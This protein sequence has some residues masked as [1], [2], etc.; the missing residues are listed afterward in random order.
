MTAGLAAEP[1]HDSATYH[2]AQRIPIGGSD[3]SYDYLRLDPATQHLY[4]AHGTRVDVLDASTGAHIGEIGRLAG[5]HGIEF[6]GEGPS[7][8]ATSGVDR[9]VVM[10]DRRSLKIQRFIK[11]TGVK[12]DALAFDPASR[13]LF[14][15]NG[16]TTG[17]LT[18]IDPASGAIIATV[19]LQGGKLE[20]IAF[21]GRG[22]GYVNDEKQSVVHVFDSRTL[23]PIARWPLGPGEEPT[24]LAMDRAGGRIFAACGNRLLV[25]VD[26]ATGRVVATAPIGADPD[27]A[28]YDAGRGRVF[29]SNRDGTLS[30]VRE[31]APGRFVPEQTVKTAP[32]ART[33][34]LD[35]SSGRLFLPY[36]EFGPAPPPTPAVPEPAAP[37]I[38]G[39][40]G[41]LVVAP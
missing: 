33:I 38:P 36:A 19:E 14:V 31:V 26:I 35:E 11:Y 21:D 9:A 7:G 20:Q 18:V 28:A 24:G 40:F 39:S 23:E 30:V 34:A 22:R 27:G 17:D 4:V 5:A 32:G 6:P 10:F 37:M 41:V 13:R 8:F 25:V 15:V 2:V 3:T 1:A 12:P 16:G 29:T